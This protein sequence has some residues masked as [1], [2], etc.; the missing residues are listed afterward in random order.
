MTDRGIQI[1]NALKRLR[2]RADISQEKLA[3]LAGISQPTYSRIEGNA[4]G[5]KGGEAIRLADA[6]GVRLGAILGAVDI[7]SRA[8]CAGR[9]D[10]GPSGMETMRERLFAYLELD[11]YLEAQGIQSGR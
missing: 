4:R 5:L 3:D 7:E 9:T 8:V 6:L 1:A 10:G 2:E 11:D